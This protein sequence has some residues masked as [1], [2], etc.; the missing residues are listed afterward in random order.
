M[1]KVHEVTR[2]ETSQKISIEHQ[3]R[4]AKQMWLPKNGLCFKVV[5]LQQDSPA[6]MHNHPQA[7]KDCKEDENLTAGL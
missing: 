4:Q 7:F 6:S 2:L 1:L 3:F 5:L